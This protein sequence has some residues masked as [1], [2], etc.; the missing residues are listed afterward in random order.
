VWLVHYNTLSKPTYYGG[1]MVHEGSHAYSSKSMEG[2]LI[3]SGLKDIKTFGLD[4]LFK[5][6]WTSKHLGWTNF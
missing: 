4:K 2:F 6:E 1:K 5:G 3:D